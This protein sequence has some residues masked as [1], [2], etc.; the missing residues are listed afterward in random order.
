[1]NCRLCMPALLSVLIAAVVTVA[2]ASAPK[3]SVATVTVA[4]SGD[5]N[6]DASGR[7][8][9]VVVRVYQLK[10]DTAFTNADFFALYDD[11]K[12]VLGA[13]LIARAEYVIAP[14]EKRSIEL[15]VS[16]EARFVGAVAAFRDIRAAQW[17][18][19]VPVSRDE[20]SVT[21]AVER[22][23]IVVSVAD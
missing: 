12:K 16:P 15:S 6:P 7:P 20:E 1:M 18:A 22:G 13:E 3:P 17:R 8:S 10:G 21:V 23:R 11:E 5:S 14:S 19:V 9:P 4:A 2:C